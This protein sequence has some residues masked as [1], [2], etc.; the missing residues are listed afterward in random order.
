MNIT[1]ITRSAGSDKRRKRVGRGRGSGRG[2]TCGRG[3]KGSGQRA[4]WGGKILREGGQM[5]AFRRIPKRGF[6]NAIFTTRYHV[7]NVS[8]LETRYEADAE[9]TLESLREVGLIRDFRKPV[10]ILGNGTLTKKLN[11]GAAKFSGKAVEKI[12]AAGGSARIVP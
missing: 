6:N 4:G 8:D 5:P 3:H 11:V 2:K 10:K 7:V 9:V 12:E 1:E